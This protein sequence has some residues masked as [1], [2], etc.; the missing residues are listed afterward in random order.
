[1]TDFD[2]SP[3]YDLGNGWIATGDR[4]EEYAANLLLDV[5]GMRSAWT[6][7]ASQAAYDAF[8]SPKGVGYVL[9]AAAQTAW[10]VGEA[11]NIY[12]E[13]LQKAVEQIDRQRVIASLIGAFESILSLATLALG[14]YLGPL[15]EEVSVI[16]EGLVKALDEAKG[17][18][19]TI[20]QAAKFTTNEVSVAAKSITAAAG[21]IL[22]G[23]NNPAIA[24]IWKVA[25]YTGEA[26]I[27][28]GGSTVGFDVSAQAI[29]AAITH[30]PLKIDWAS[31]AMNAGMGTLLAA[32]G[33]EA[34]HLKP[35]R[36][37][38]ELEPKTGGTVSVNVPAEA[39]P[40]TPGFTDPHP[41][42]LPG[43]SVPTL[44]EITPPRTTLQSDGA[45][46]ALHVGGVNEAAAPPRASAGNTGG[47]T[48]RPDSGQPQSAVVTTS[49]K[50]GGSPVLGDPSPV[51]GRPQTSDPRPTLEGEGGGGAHGEVTGS[52]TPTQAK[53]GAF[54]DGPPRG[55][56]ADG[57]ASP[58][59][60]LSTDASTGAGAG[61][62]VGG[63]TRVE[64]VAAGGDGGARA[65]TGASR[66]T[67]E[68][69][70]DGGARAVAGGGIRVEAGAGDK[71]RNV[72]DASAT[73]GT[74]RS[75]GG[76]V[77]TGGRGRDASG[78]DVSR[79]TADE[80][81]GGRRGT[82]A[83]SAQESA[84]ELS[85]AGG[86]RSSDMGSHSFEERQSGPA[87][88]SGADV[89]AATSADAR[90]RASSSGIDDTPHALEQGKSGLPEDSVGMPGALSKNGDA[91]ALP[92]EKAPGTGTADKPLGGPSDVRE[93]QPNEDIRFGEAPQPTKVQMAETPEGHSAE[94]VDN[95]G[96]SGVDSSGRLSPSAEPG[97]PG[98]ASDAG[99]GLS[100][101]APKSEGVGG[102]ERLTGGRE[103][104]DVGS[105]DSALLT[106]EEGKTPAPG[107]ERPVGDS[108]G[109]AGTSASAIDDS[110]PSLDSDRGNETSASSSRRDSWVSGRSSSTSSESDLGNGRVTDHGA[111]STRADEHP[112][113]HGA[114]AKDDP[115]GVAEPSSRPDE[116]Y[117]PHRADVLSKPGDSGSAHEMFQNAV[118]HQ[119][120]HY[121]VVMG[122]ADV[123][124]EVLE[125]TLPGRFENAHH[126][127]E[128]ELGIGQP[129]LSESDRAELL[130]ELKDTLTKD[131]NEKLLAPGRDFS[132]LTK[133]QVDSLGAEWNLH[134][135]ARVEQLPSRFA[136]KLAVG[137]AEKTAK[138]QVSDFIDRHYRDGVD[139]GEAHWVQRQ[140]L[141]DVKS[142]LGK[143]G[144]EGDAAHPTMSLADTLLDRFDHA[145]AAGQQ[146][147]RVLD[148]FDALV[149]Q[150]LD[151]GDIHLTRVEIEEARNAW[152]ESAK[153]ELLGAYTSPDGFRGYG[154]DSAAVDKA[155][156]A[157]V[158]RLQAQLDVEFNH[159]PE[160]DARL[161]N[162]QVAGGHPALSMREA[163]DSLKSD[164]FR[165]TEQHLAE[166][167]HSK[168]GLTPEAVA[169]SQ[170]VLDHKIDKLVAPRALDLRMRFH[171][172]LREA[173]DQI[174]EAV[175]L[176]AGTQLS[177]SELDH[178]TTEYQ[179]KIKASADQHLSEL[180][181]GHDRGHGDTFDPS[182]QAWRDDVAKELSDVAKR[183]GKEKLWS[184]GTKLAGEE[185]SNHFGGTYN[186]RTDDP[187][188]AGLGDVA[189]RFRDDYVRLFDKHY[190]DGAAG[191][192]DYLSHDSAK[193]SFQKGIDDHVRVS[194]DQRALDA[195]HQ[196]E[197]DKLSPEFRDLKTLKE[198]LNDAPKVPAAGKTSYRD[199][200]RVETPGTVG[201]SIK[202][203][204]NDNIRDLNKTA[205]SVGLDEMTSEYKQQIRDAIAVKDWA[206][207]SELIEKFRGPVDAKVLNNRLEDFRSFAKDDGT[208]KVLDLGGSEEQLKAHIAAI[209]SAAKEGPDALR[210]ALDNFNTY[211]GK[212]GMDSRFNNLRR[213]D[214]STRTGSND[215][216]LD[217]LYKQLDDT[218]NPL[219]AEALQESINERRDF[220]FQQA[221]EEKT[222]QLL[223]SLPGAA[224]HDPAL[225][226]DAPSL[227]KDD[228][229]AVSKDDAAPTSDAATP[230]AADA[231]DT[232]AHGEAGTDDHTGVSDADR[233]Q[234]L[235]ALKSKPE[236]GG[237]LPSQEQLDQRLEALK[238][239]QPSLSEGPG[240]G[241]AHDDADR[242]QRL[243]ALKC[244]PEDG[245]DL[246][247][248]EQLD[249]RLEALK[250]YQ[251][252]LS[253]G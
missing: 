240:K 125:H 36:G 1:M 253:E 127:W 69:G 51:V 106:G 190:G 176:H 229:P 249:Q 175:T 33:M 241:A 139:A 179:N 199:G 2:V 177:P 157:K 77:G 172:N 100:S 153:S 250:K 182:F 47:I 198:R 122:L 161:D 48:A 143:A 224:T 168:G 171:T 205:K 183:V 71:V 226:K 209:E 137:Q 192:D 152:E 167:S 3:I 208:A 225:P 62:S 144:V 213:D 238:K 32:G 40:S 9:T 84:D 64:P 8:T 89:H 25:S 115:H 74:P 246:P 50:S 12:A 202:Q 97:A 111:P 104:T 81:R 244:K 46:S 236:D 119:L 30:T 70:A 215:P 31:E 212:L 123:R 150:H 76:Q 178:I 128:D 78:A 95:W 15:L 118:N 11:I 206:K 158:A 191:V 91:V 141:G 27:V 72:A 54:L 96:V 92:G 53:P 140:Y 166:L 200:V 151:A 252:S 17:I 132:N 189:D 24:N 110:R 94:I 4:L 45:P 23:L 28:G 18:I 131:F 67:A 87:A 5:S 116:G 219:K 197:L 163:V 121:D 218:K 230:P 56:S 155:F 146:V 232:G 38:S 188:R 14:V 22:S 85:V 7:K 204:V 108:T 61:G 57:T 101:E 138:S 6:G 43:N 37:G 58:A 159:L 90:P 26:V 107:A 29:A 220:L 102:G 109:K 201:K 223:D 35:L 187:L 112:G 162:A 216:V 248:Q 133:D 195:L 10:K 239:Y 66:S 217:D 60:P 203:L 234:R 181:L 170:S 154:S 227:S 242:Q 149:K 251:P 245:G 130:Q 63:G 79:G 194:G 99:S 49:G 42:E 83:S 86:E 21:D 136:D 237:D 184:N 16:I 165:V 114:P 98:K 173:F 44:G 103:N 214:F 126:Q 39:K 186:I 124:N 169:K 19:S 55:A 222:A 221:A 185:F 180:L 88:A 13:E 65:V 207:A 105:N 135:D 235:D 120:G 117:G 73:A 247:S 196:R 20:W 160:L 93:G 243:D 174:D 148:H 142:E 156:N 52:V 80:A 164:I 129:G 145:A 233:Q 231:K 210:G 68:G 228:A 59:T 147:G 34:P 113:E 211:A 193:E 82:G 75:T 134:V 41:T